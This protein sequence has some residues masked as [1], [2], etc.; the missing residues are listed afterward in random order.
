MTIKEK[1]EFDLKFYPHF[2][3]HVSLE[4]IEAIVI[5]PVKVAQ[6]PFFPFLE[7]TKKQRKFGRTYK[8]RKIRYASRLSSYI[9]THYRG[10]LS[11]KYER[12]LIENNIRDYPL[13]Y[14]KIVDTVSGEQFGKCNIHFAKEAFDEISKRGAC[15]AICLD[16]SSFFDSIDH[17]KLYELWCNLLMTSELPDDHQA[18]FNAITS[19]TVVDRDDCYV[20]LGY[21]VETL[22][23]GKIQKKLTRPAKHIPMQLCTPKIFRE[24]ICSGLDKLTRKNNKK[25]G[26][27]QGAPLSDLLANLYLLNFDGEISSLEKKLGGYYRRYSDD[28]LFICTNKEEIPLII[29][30]IKRELKL[31]GEELKINDKKT[32]ITE[33]YYDSETLRCRPLNGKNNSQKPM[34]YLGFSFDGQQVL[35]KNSTLSGYFRNMKYESRRQASLLIRDFPK[36]KLEEILLIGQKR[37]PYICQKYGNIE[38]FDEEKVDCKQWNFRSYATKASRVMQLNGGH[39]ILHQLR[40]SKKRL[41]RFLEIEIQKAY[42]KK[43]QSL[44]TKE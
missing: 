18:L 25:Y 39:R 33:F 17:N 32:N 4:K 22:V 38:D 12:S 23:R 43:R 8:E 36:K 11:E 1:S 42:Y 16:I 5:N 37:F 7:Y 44:H 20:R 29:N 2:D 31:V 34:E 30:C 41:K 26:L 13:A 24:K 40:D 19:Y 28:I 14:R 3:E 9:F 21:M 27:P 10:I 35:I 15:F 6:H